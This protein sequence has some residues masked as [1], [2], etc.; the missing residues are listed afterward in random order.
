[1]QSADALAHAHDN[2]VLHRDIKPSNIMLDHARSPV[3]R[4]KLLDFGIAKLMD[5]EQAIDLT[6]PGE[7]LGSPPYM[8]PEQSLGKK[9][10]TRSD[11]YSLGCVMYE[12]LTLAPPFVSDSAMET[13]YK[14]QTENPLSLSEASLGQSFDPR[15]EGLILKMLSKDPARE[16][17]VDARSSRR[18]G[19]DE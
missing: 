14:H 12:T 1:M 16:T 9:V 15:L 8:S 17:A 4:V 18:A 2:G 5:E 11:I 3:P 10:D 7:V 6:N 19:Q 13:I